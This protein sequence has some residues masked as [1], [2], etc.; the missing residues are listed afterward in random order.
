MKY[1]KELPGNIKL[2]YSKFIPTFEDAYRLEAH[3]VG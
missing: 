3:P 2:A 1:R